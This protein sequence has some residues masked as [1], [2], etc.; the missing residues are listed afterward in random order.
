MKLI[1]KGV[2]YLWDYQDQWPFDAL[3]KAIISAPLLSAPNYDRDF[4][5]YLASSPSY[6]GMVLVQTHDDLS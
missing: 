6:L 4:L 2:P 5:L 1:K 3:K